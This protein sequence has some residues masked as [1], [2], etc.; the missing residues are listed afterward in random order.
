MKRLLL[1]LMLLALAAC[2]SNPRVTNDFSPDVDFGA[3][4]TYSWLVPPQGVSPL[5]QSRIVSSVDQQLQ[6]KG[7][8]RVEG[9]AGQVTVA[10]HVIIR[11]QQSIDTL[12]TGPAFSG[13]GWNDPWRRGPGMHSRS[14]GMT[15]TNVRTYDVG[16]LVVDMFMTD[17]RQ[18]IWRGTADRT[19]PSSPQ[20]RSEVVQ[21]G[22]EQMFRDFPP[23]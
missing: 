23:M 3:I 13:W 2:S 15:T 11:Q 10:A 20:R 6:S 7:W 16:T 14:M 9:G 21:I 4:K 22:I 5:V 19:V 1:S 12:Y 18:A 17:S 8:E